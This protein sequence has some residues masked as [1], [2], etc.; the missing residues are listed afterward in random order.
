MAKRSFDPRVAYTGS[1]VQ[2]RDL[3][4]IVGIIDPFG[5]RG[6]GTWGN[7]FHRALGGK[8]AQETCAGCP[9][10]GR[11]LVRIVEVSCG[12]RAREV[13]VRGK[14]GLSRN[15]GYKTSGVAMWLNVVLIPGLPTPDPG[16]GP[17]ENCGY[18]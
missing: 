5:P 8:C 9:Q 1:K 15:L 2:V 17:S 14:F 4:R 18:Y 10:Q 3:V 13:R 12:Y 6:V 16:T 11:D 7:S